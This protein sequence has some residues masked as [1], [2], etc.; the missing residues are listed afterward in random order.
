VGL[1]AGEVLQQVSIALRRHDTQV[2]A[3]AVV[4][5]D[6]RLGPSVRDYLGDPGL[7]D[8]MRG[9][10]GGVFGGGDDV[11]VANRLP[12]AAH[13]SRFGNVVGGRMGAQLLHDLVDRREHAA[14]QRLLLD[15]LLRLR[16]RRQHLLLRLRP[17]PLHLGEPAL[18]GRRT[19]IVRRLHPEL[20]PELARSLRAE[21]GNVHDVHEPG[22]KLVAQLGE[23]GQVAG[24][25]VLDDLPLDGGADPRESGRLLVERQLGDR[26]RGLADPRRSPAVGAQAKRV[27]SV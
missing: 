27:R 13:A 25:R 12:A 1:R 19:K 18:L 5:D 3:Q 15:R 11:E 17:E 7:R 6:S 16:E 4:G 20:H 9:Q 14:E 24:L 2:E 8:E 23:R 22:R 21:A 10:G 26:N